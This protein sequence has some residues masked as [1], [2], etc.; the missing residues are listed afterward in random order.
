MKP[1]E[2]SPAR[3]LVA[4]ITNPKD[5]AHIV[6]CGIEKLIEF[7]DR[8]DINSPWLCW[9]V[10]SGSRAALMTVSPPSTRHGTEPAR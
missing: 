9:I 3:D 1:T 2:Q 6:D 4:L 10:P 8:G 7:T 5:L